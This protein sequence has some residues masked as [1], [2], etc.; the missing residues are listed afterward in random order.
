[1]P[2]VVATTSSVWNGKR[3]PVELF[4]VLH[5][6]CRETVFLLRLS[7]EDAQRLLRLKDQRL[8][9][10]DDDVAFLNPAVGGRARWVNRGHRHDRLTSVVACGHQYQPECPR[11]VVVEGGRL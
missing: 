11:P 10:L 1:M 9:R 4:I 8:L 6:N 5:E 3:Q 2:W 7:S